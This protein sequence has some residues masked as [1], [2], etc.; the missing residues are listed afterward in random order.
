MRCYLQSLS[1]ILLG[2]CCKMS[3]IMN[4]CQVEMLDIYD[5]WQVYMKLSG[6]EMSDT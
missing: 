6:I 5:L 1:G 3:A 2:T 4:N